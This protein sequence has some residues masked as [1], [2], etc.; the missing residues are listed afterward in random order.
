M[1]GNRVNSRAELGRRR[2]KE[3]SDDMG[4]CVCIWGGGRRCR[5][6][7]LWPRGVCMHGCVGRVCGHRVDLRDSQPEQLS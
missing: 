5:A 1:Y 3:G 6:A 4:T 2:W 7:D